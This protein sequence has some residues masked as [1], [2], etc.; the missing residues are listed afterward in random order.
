MA[1]HR[2]SCMMNDQERSGKRVTAT[3]PMA[4]LSLQSHVI[5]QRKQCRSTSFF[6]FLL[7]Y[8]LCTHIQI[9]IPTVSCTERGTPW[10]L[11]ADAVTFL[12]GM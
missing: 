5:Q 1:S 7:V 3:S 9:Y 8:I 2:P 11:E 6:L 10:A 4:F 12:G